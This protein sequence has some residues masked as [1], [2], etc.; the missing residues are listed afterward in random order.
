MNGHP[1]HSR[2]S[3]VGL[4][5]S[6]CFF[7]IFSLDHLLH[8]PFGFSRAFRPALRRK[9]F[10][11]SLDSP[12]SF[13][14]LRCRKGQFVLDFLPLFAHESRCLLALPFKS[15]DTVRAFPTRVSTMPS[16]DFCSRVRAPCDT[17]SH[18]FVTTNR[19]PEVISTAFRAPPPN[20][21]SASLME[22]GFAITGPLAQRSRLLFGF[23]SSARTFAPRFLPTPPRSD[24]SALR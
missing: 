5:S 1:I 17:L 11:P 7:E 9:R 24:A 20:L 21:R 22:M 8:Q 13:T 14:P 10:G 19:P 23:C 18:A 15:Y 4:D 6:Q 2:T 16:A 12:R 3:L